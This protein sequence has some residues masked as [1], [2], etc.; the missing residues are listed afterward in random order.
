MEVDEPVL[1]AE[2][3]TEKLSG[4]C[5]TILFRR[6]KQRK[7]QLSAKEKQVLENVRKL[8]I[9]DM[10][11]LQAMNILYELHKKSSETCEYSD[12]D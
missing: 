5:T 2:I 4:R 12:K 7:K 9:L 8:D 1:N 6:I 3:A 11:P 10:T